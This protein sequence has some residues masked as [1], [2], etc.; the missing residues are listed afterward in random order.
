[1]KRATVAAG[2]VHSLLEFAVGEGVSREVLLGRAALDDATLADRDARVPLA[3]YQALIAAAIALSGDKALP[4]RYS[5]STRFEDISI[6]GLIVHASSSMADSLQQLNRYAKLMVEVE[7]MPGGGRR[8]EVEAEGGE[9]W[10]VD[11]RPDPN[12]FPELT[13][14][15]FGRLIGEFRRHFPSVPFALA[16]DFTHAEPAHADACRE[17]LGVP[18]RF[19]TVRN[20]LRIAPEWLETSFDGDNSYVFGVFADRAD[21]LMARLEADQSLRGRIESRLLPVLHRGEVSM[22]SLASELGMSRQTLYRKLREE[23]TTF[24]ELV[25]D[26]R[27][28]MAADY[29]RARKVSVNE[30]AYLVGF[31]EPSSFV[32]AFRRWT[33]MTPSAFRQGGDVRT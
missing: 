8:F 1:V 32:R 22:D 5:V 30:T 15:A 2:I 31:T 26:L 27:R 14:I 7:V 18:V 4:L 24:V 23:G 12:A 16:I 9:V 6:V 11:Q 21:A 28:R 29:L 20:A 10:I 19:D 3:S 13:E 33:G 17:L 25:D